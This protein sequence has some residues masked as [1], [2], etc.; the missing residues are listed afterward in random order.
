MDIEQGKL[1]DFS[2][3]A[4]VRFESLDEHRRFVRYAPPLLLNA[5]FLRISLGIRRPEEYPLTREMRVETL[6]RVAGTLMVYGYGAESSDP[7]PEA[8]I[9]K[10]IT[11][12]LARPNQ[13]AAL[14]SR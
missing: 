11:D 10:T 7:K 3:S 14:S 6:G 2:E 1:T 8:A 9:L 5:E 12:Y 4:L 13:P